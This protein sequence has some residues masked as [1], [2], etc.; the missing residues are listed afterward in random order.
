[1]ALTITLNIIEGYVI[2]VN[3][4][5]SANIPKFRTISKL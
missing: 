1:M 5:G 4:N 3:K 2:K